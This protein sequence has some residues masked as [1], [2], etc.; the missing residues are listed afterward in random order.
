MVNYEIMKKITSI[1]FVALALA[2]V[3]CTPEDLNSV[4]EI[5][6][7]S[8]TP[9]DAVELT[10]LAS[11]TST[12]STDRRYFD[13]SF[14]GSD[15][16]LE[17]RLVGFDALLPTGQY[18]LG[19]DEIG[20]A[21]AEKTKVNGASVNSGFITVTKKGSDYNIIASLDDKVYS[22]TGAL[23]FVA[24]P[25]PVLL[26][27][28]MNAQSNLANG[29]QSLTMNLATEGISQEFDMTTYQQV[30]K[31]EGGYLALDIFSDDGYLHEGSYKPCAE[32]GVIGAG[33]FG[34][35]YDTTMEFWGQ[36]YEMKD[37]GT[38]WWA[39]S[40]GAATATKILNGLVTVS[41]E[42]DEWTISWGANYPKEYVFKGAI[43]ALTKPSGGQG[44]ES[45]SI[46]YTYTEAELQ[47]VTDTG[48]NIIAGVKKH[49]ITIWDKEGN[50]KAYLELLIADGE[51]N[52]EGSYPST[53]YASQPGQMADGWE[54]DA[55]AWGGTLMS[56][57]SYFVNDA[58]EKVLMYAG[59]YTVEVTK[60]ATGAYRFS[61]SAFDYSAAGPDYVPGD[62]P[63]GGGD[64]TG[65]TLT[66]FLSVTS[67]KGYGISLAGV[68]LATPGVS[69]ETVID[70]TNW[71]ATTTYYGEGNYVKLEYYCDSETGLP[72][73]GTYKACET[74][75]TVNPGEFN[76]GYDNSGN[77]YGSNWYTVAGGSC[78]NQYITDGT[79]T[80]EKSG[81]T[82]TIILESS[83]VNFKYVG[84]LSK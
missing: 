52:Y 62:N 63:G 68:E 5:T 12:W 73:P 38:C 40:N 57:G 34:I 6:D 21:V 53:S 56:G 26:T 24:D 82:Y 8:K 1:L 75:G 70:W 54:F 42:D 74:V 67:Y 51:T 69:Y 20:K 4:N 22:W 17:T 33:E 71:T 23:P 3:S 55:T 35:G 66:D 28:V 39:V 15:A 29:V 37:W 50:E 43:P 2:I 46:D 76:V 58:G 78:T 25:D 65:V 64:F 27:V 13:L 45:G 19:G 83:V 79:L 61:C 36:V 47:D 59:Q 11:A 14:A 49:P 18:V 16:S 81:D 30:W 10:A 48:G 41:R 32:G 72:E 44:G 9:A 60:I 77:P 84:P 80:V 31:G 7:H